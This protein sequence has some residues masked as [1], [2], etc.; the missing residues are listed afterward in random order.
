MIATRRGQHAAAFDPTAERYFV[1]TALDS[2]GRALYIGRSCN[3]AARLRSHHST[4][5]HQGV[6]D[7]LKAKWI[8]E[9]R[10]L[11]LIGPFT[12][13]EAVRVERE[14]IEHYQPT[15]NRDLTARDRR[16]AVA[17]RSASRAGG[18]A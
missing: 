7:R 9:A 15:G 3:V 8:L 16:P 18:V 5:N 11:R 13:K 10:D 4:L 17:A 14:Q 2:R 6:P 12:W 1:Y